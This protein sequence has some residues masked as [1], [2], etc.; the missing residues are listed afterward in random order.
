MQPAVSK[1]ERLHSSGSPDHGGHCTARSTLVLDELEA[2]RA[3]ERVTQRL[4]HPLR[5]HDKE[6]PVAAS[7]G[8]AMSGASVHAQAL[9]EA[10]D[11][12]MYSAKRQRAANGE[13]AARR[14]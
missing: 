8:V 11:A 7:I 6:L 4:S 9:L 12:S 5:A 2:R 1:L 13:W 14:A 3:A 10:A